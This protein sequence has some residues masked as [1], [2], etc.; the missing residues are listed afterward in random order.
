MNLNKK[1]FYL[2]FIHYTE[3]IYKKSFIAKTKNFYLNKA[4]SHF[5]NID[6]VPKIVVII[7]IKLV[8][9]ISK[10]FF[11]TEFYKINE[12][13]K[14]K[15][16]FYLDYVFRFI[17][18]KTNELLLSLYL[19]QSR[20]NESIKEIK[21]KTQVIKNY[22]RF[23]VIGSG[24]AG[25][26]TAFNLQKEFSDVLL[27]EKGSYYKIPK[28]KHPGDEFIKKWDNSGVLTTLYPNQINFS[29]GKC[30]GGGSEINSGLY[31]Y[32][33]EEFFKVWQK[34]NKIYNFN[35]NYINKINK[36]LLKKISVNKLINT[37]ANK[38]YKEFCEGSKINNTVAENIS[39]LAEKK[40]G[41]YK[42][43]SMSK[44]LLKEFTNL[45]GNILINSTVNKILKNRKN[46]WEISV[47]NQ[48]PS[49][50]T[51]KYLFLCAGSTNTQKLLI[52]S[53][54]SNK[55]YF[56]KFK[57]HPMIKVIP[58][59]KRN[60]QNGFNDV[61]SYQITK[62][63]PNFILGEA[64]SGKQFLEM[65]VLDNKNILN[66]VKNNWKKMSIYHSTFSFGSGK[67]IKLPFLNK[68]IYSYQIKNYELNNIKFSLKTLCKV[69]F[70]GGA[71]Y[72]YLI[73][74]EKIK[75]YPFNFKKIINSI[76]SI[77]DLKFSSVHILGKIE[78][79][80]KAFCYVDSFGK[81]KKCENIFIND[82]SLISAPL[83][84]NPQGTIMILAYRNI[85]EFI[86][87]L[88]QK[89]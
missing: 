48:K 13:Q 32:P 63:Y 25:S 80:E 17:T 37:N 2:N 44:T 34:K 71:E 23:I 30:L 82:S 72:I 3:F 46:L 67:I 47:N 49:T 15:I 58:K 65:S 31:H 57:L 74:K 85:L 52:N 16:C 81:I 50:L 51:C 20:N 27:I 42:K 73:N 64:S 41:I 6:F 43:N 26:I 76:N 14:S 18:K 33:K 56:N 86:K 12:N 59:F 5:N 61:H 70:N 69:L 24:P 21:I 35:F 79:G 29:S 87:N 55:N 62:F 38:S 75:A 45:N 68:Y 10:I 78:M 4:F 77:Q 83:L 88:K 9:I 8:N 1:K 19:I 60:V 28:T 11:R 36:K 89:E 54:F 66:D 40:N 39:R 22:Y 84:Q 53:N 7:N